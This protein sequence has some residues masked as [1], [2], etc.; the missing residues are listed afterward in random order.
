[1]KKG[2]LGR[3]QQRRLDRILDG[4]GGG[5]SSHCLNWNGAIKIFR[6]A[7]NFLLFILGTMPVNA[8]GWGKDAEDGD[9]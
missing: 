3:Q 7:S 5:G 1:M 8:G 4:G 9:S 2:S 6:R